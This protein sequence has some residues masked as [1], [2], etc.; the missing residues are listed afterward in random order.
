[1]PPPNLITQ[2]IQFAAGIKGRVVRWADAQRTRRRL[3]EPTADTFVTG[4]PIL[5]FAPEAGAVPHVAAQFLLGRT[6]Q[7]QGHS[8]LFTFC[9]EVFSRCPVL[10]MHRVGYEHPS[11]RHRAACLSC[12]T[13]AFRMFDEYPL[14]R[15]DLR[16]LATD[17]L[18]R[19]ARN[20]VA[21][22]PSDLREFEY[23]GILF[24]LLSAMD[25][26]LA[27][28]ISNFDAIDDVH[29]QVWLN[30]AENSLLA[31]LLTG[32]ICDQYSIRRLV[33]FNDYSL[34]LGARLAA[35]ERGIPAVS[36]TLA[37]HLNN[38]RRHIVL[39][40]ETGALNSRRVGEAWP[41]FRDLPL[42]AARVRQIGD[43]ILA[44][45]G[46]TGSHTFS[47]AK[48]VGK[49]D[50]RPDWGLSTDKRLIVAF[51][52]SLDE[53][54]AARMTLA[55]LRA[56]LPP[57]HHTFG[58]QIGWLKALVAYVRD[59]DDLELAVR[60]HPREGTGCANGAAS[61]IQPIS[62]QHLACLREAFRQPFPN[63]KFFWPD[64]E[65]SSYDLAEVA[66][67]G[68]VSWST[69]GIE[70][71]RMGIPV[72]ASSRGISYFPAD[73]FIE[74]ANEPR[75][76][77]AKLELLLDSPPALGTIVRAFRWYSMFHLGTSI[78]VS[79]VVPRDDFWGLPV[80]RT[81]REAAAIEQVLVQGQ[82]PLELNLTRLKSL[83]VLETSRAET[84]EIQN[85]LC[86]LIMFMM[87]GEDKP[88]A[89]CAALIARLSADSDERKNSGEKVGIVSM[90]NNG[91]QVT[92]YSPLCSRLF[93]MLTQSGPKM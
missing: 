57:P 49:T 51:T 36:V 15:L 17:D 1:M 60:V 89:E 19:Q 43:D 64:N 41:Q 75:E 8:V 7:E 11:D 83:P 37:P 66:S 87:T 34:M 42:P 38:S 28:K 10:E 56:A 33:Y 46:G 55:G 13:E 73:D 25:L 70:M 48:T 93:S 53:M 86:R 29:R 26:V 44:R 68:L 32:K 72:L 82:D 77:F 59:R 80:Y 39:R 21:Q 61:K 45:L 54:L 85:Q 3:R 4:E 90:C 9:H 50:P 35:E 18:K 71:A 58:D 84:D 52:S 62:S 65:V 91:R 23:N 2:S 63:C 22:A 79:D 27:R 24:G 14:P 76:Y 30:F 88:A 12:A 74:F 78:D 6:L 5:F 92:R 20:A 81:P 47:P 16:G 67:V 31:Y 69:I 40:P